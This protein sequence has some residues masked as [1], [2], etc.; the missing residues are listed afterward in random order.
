MVGAVVVGV[1][2]IGGGS[3]KAIGKAGIALGTGLAGSTA[4][5]F[6]ADTVDAIAG[7]A[8][9]ASVARIPL[10][11]FVGALVAITPRTGSSVTVAVIGATG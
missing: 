6:T 2:A 9:G 10:V 8:F 1:L 7:G 11:L 4:T 5:G 3:T